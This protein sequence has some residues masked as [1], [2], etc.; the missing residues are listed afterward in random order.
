MKTY[1]D[2][3]KSAKID[4]VSV[5]PNEK[6]LNGEVTPNKAKRE[7]IIQPARGSLYQNM[8]SELNQKIEM[9]RK[10]YDAERQKL[11]DHYQKHDQNHNNQAKTN[12][13]QAVNKAS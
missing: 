6:R 13:Y 3:I 7:E 11:Y 5:T 2:P 10:K 1:E 4:R 12:T 9:I 8:S